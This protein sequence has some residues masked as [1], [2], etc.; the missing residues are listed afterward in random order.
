MAANPGIFTAGQTHLIS[1][2]SF[3]LQNSLWRSP[4]KGLERKAHRNCIGNSE[5][6]ERK[7]RFFAVQPQKMRPD[8]SQVVFPVFFVI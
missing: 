7:A 5:D 3:A 2:G 1:A 6:L 4:R 8:Y